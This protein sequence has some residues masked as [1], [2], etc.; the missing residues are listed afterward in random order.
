MV[1]STITSVVKNDDHCQ[2]SIVSQDNS[3]ATVET[4]EVFEQ[5]SNDMGLPQSNT[6][7][8][9]VRPCRADAIVTDTQEQ[10]LQ[11]KSELLVELFVYILLCCQVM[12]QAHVCNMTCHAM[13]AH[14]IK[15]CPDAV[16]EWCLPYTWCVIPDL[17]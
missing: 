6:L 2:Y 12:P 8:L 11:Q 17:T 13:K 3:D 7:T 16:Q 9:L 4:W 5:S 1:C 15:G 14:L 10:D